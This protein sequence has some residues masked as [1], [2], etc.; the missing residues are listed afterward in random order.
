MEIPQKAKD[1]TAIGSSD[2]TPGHIPRGNKSGYNRDTCILMFITVLFI[3][4]KLW[5][6]PRYS[7]TDEWIKRM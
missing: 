4:A 3:I 6:Q 1:T 2:T 7:T 5:K